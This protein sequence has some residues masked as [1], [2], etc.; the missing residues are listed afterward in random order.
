MGTYRLR[1]SAEEVL[2][3]I[4]AFCCEE[5]IGDV[6]VGRKDGL[7]EARAPATPDWSNARWTW[8]CRCD[9]GQTTLE[10]RLR[11]PLL[12]TQI[13]YLAVGMLS[14][15]SL[16]ASIVLLA[17]GIEGVAPLVASLCVACLGILLF[18]GLNLPAAELAMVKL[19]QRFTERLLPYS[20]L[21]EL[22]PGSNIFP[23]WATVC[24]LSVPFG[25]LLA[26]VTRVCPVLSV[27]GV[28]ILLLLLS[29]GLAQQDASNSPFVAWRL[30]L[31]GW[32]GAR[33]L[34]CYFAFIAVAMFIVLGGAVLAFPQQGEARLTK[35]LAA[36][37]LRTPLTP[38]GKTSPG[39]LPTDAALLQE[40]LEM[41]DTKDP[42]RVLLTVQAGRL[43]LIC[44]CTGLLFLPARSFLNW[45]RVWSLTKPRTVPEFSL[46]PVETRSLHGGRSARVCLALSL[47]F[48]AVANVM[49]FLL[50]VEITSVLIFDRSILNRSVAQAIGW[51][52]IDLGDAAKGRVHINQ[53]AAAFAVLLIMPTLLTVASWIPFVLKSLIGPLLRSLISP[54]CQKLTEVAKD[55]SSA[56][57]IRT[58]S[59]RLIGGEGPCLETRVPW[60]FGGPRIL[61]TRGALEILSESELAAALA[62]E[63]SHIR[64][65]AP[66][67]RLTQVL[68]VLSFFPC[69][70]FALLLNMEEREK[71]ADTVAVQLVG[72]KGAMA[73][74]LV[75]ASLV[76]AFWIHRPARIG[77]SAPGATSASRGGAGW[78]SHLALFGALFQPELILGYAHPRLQDRLRSLSG[79]DTSDTKTS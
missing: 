14:A 23:T 11:A 2:E 49:H 62:H 64:F 57:G 65:D 27:P 9:A 26:G 1:A 45:M 20:A 12:K 52:V 24:F 32:L 78:L 21:A 29:K 48:A 55:L 77:K 69:N 75:K 37:Q 44:F 60:L 54:R 15:G 13:L 72:D 63:V 4:Q 46:L 56:L 25:L 17:W 66:A 41:A 16:A 33:S 70:V 47:V 5:G 34:F 50:T 19:E 53:V 28:P 43:L 22:P 58:P 73:S 35:L 3:H 6:H 51:M 30:L 40:I 18:T 68:S 10:V 39:I 42:G 74:A 7:L 38:E 71:R 79:N 31:S 36:V 67:L 76:G 8:V 59:V 61:V